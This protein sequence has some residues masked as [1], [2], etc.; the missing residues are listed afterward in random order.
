MS[1][2]HFFSLVQNAALDQR[3]HMV[4]LYGFPIKGNGHVPVHMDLYIHCK[5]SHYRMGTIFIII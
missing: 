5:D 4:K 1:V 3:S 2:W